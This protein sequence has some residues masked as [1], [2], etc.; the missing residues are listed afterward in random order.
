MDDVIVVI[1][2]EPMVQGVRI[3]YERLKSQCIASNMAEPKLL[4]LP[5]EDPYESIKMIRDEIMKTPRH[6]I[7][8]EIGAGL[9]ILPIYA[10]I[11]LKIIDKPYTIHYIPEPGTAPQIII[12]ETYIA[13]VTTGITNIE[14]KS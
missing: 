12:T 4:N 3:A 10:M 9:R 6:S 7:I 5:C 13:T 2:C 1:T 8:L 11:A 14:N